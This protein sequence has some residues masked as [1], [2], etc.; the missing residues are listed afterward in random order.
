M[1][2]CGGTLVVNFF[3]FGYTC[4]MWKFR[5]QGTN[6]YH[7]CNQSQS[8]EKAISLNPLSHEQNP[9]GYSFECEWKRRGRERLVRT[10]ENYSQKDERNLFLNSTYI[11]FP[12]LSRYQFTPTFKIQC[13]LQKL[14]IHDLT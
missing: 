2:N 8:S 6:L 5:G 4:G 3:I 13:F 7:S 9:G 11:S 10:G 14:A 12:Y 1:I